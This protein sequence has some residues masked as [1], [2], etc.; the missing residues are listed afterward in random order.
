MGCRLLECAKVFGGNAGRERDKEGRLP[1]KGCL[2]HRRGG[3]CLWPQGTAWG[4]WHI[5]FSVSVP[6]RTRTVGILL[7]HTSDPLQLETQ[8]SSL[9]LAELLMMNKRIHQSLWKPEG[10]LFET[11]RRFVQGQEA[12]NPVEGWKMGSMPA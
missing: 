11:G 3:S 12:L 9:C 1:E 4:N 10:D 6:R 8:R 7:R 5:L 2:S